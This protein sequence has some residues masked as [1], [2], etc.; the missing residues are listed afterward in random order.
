MKSFA[1]RLICFF[2]F[3][4]CFFIAAYA[5]KVYDFDATCQQAYKE[6]TS[7]RLANGQKLTAQARQE[8]PDNLI[9]DLLDSYVDFFVLF[10]NED[11]AELK[12][13]E[14]HF[15]QYLDKLGD[16]PDSSPFY[17]Y[18][19]AVVLIQQA[20]V[21][22]KFGERWSAG[23][24][25]RK[26]FSLIKD[27]KKKFPAFMPNNML[28]GPMQ[29]V[30]G[31]IPDG[32]KWLAGLFGIKGSI[33]SGMA[34]MQRVIDSDDVYAKLFANEAAFYYCYVM[35][36]M[37]NQPE[38]VFKF[39]N[40]RRFDLVNNHLL[41]YM[42]ANLAINNK[43][44][45]YARSII[46]NRNNSSA[47]MQTPVWNFE[48]AYV[49]M[50][51]LELADAIRNYEYYLSH[52]KGKFYVKDACE[53]L[54]WCYYLQGNMSA[55][56]NA[57]QMVLKRGNTD[58]D[59]DKEAYKN[60]K[61]GRWPNA[62]LLKARILNDGGYNDQAIALLQDK[63][64]GDFS[65]PVDQLEFTYRTGRIYDD[66]NHNDSAVKHYLTAISLGENRTEYYASRAALQ[67]GMIYEKQGNKAMAIQYYKK[68]LAMQNHDYKDSMDQKAKSGIARC[69]GE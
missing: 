28:Y 12:V 5:D 35:F 31:T 15:D 33:S 47:Y 64:A 9:P 21:E 42:A 44:N 18:S 59:A 62:V 32:Y 4:F 63:T 52:F 39:I 67:I 65:D 68:C 23:W 56:N 37:Q 8:N 41:A 3:S 49:Q 46:Q 55:A 6:I 27:N 51:H 10:F 16:G 17:N 25:F 1:Q 54:S 66:M 61:S 14:P 60:A 22:I 7:L 13:R 69:S 45:E 40:Q 29:I 34:L 53:K 48:L 11:P 43:M 30:A 58:T 38:Q 26:A 19:R 36:Y 50:R 57:R 24:D 20:C 2:L